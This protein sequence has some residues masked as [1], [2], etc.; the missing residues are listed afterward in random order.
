MDDGRWT[1]DDGRWTMD[2]GRWTMDDGR[3][4]MDNFVGKREG[5][6]VQLV[7]GEMSG[8]RFYWLLAALR[9]SQVTECKQ[10]YSFLCG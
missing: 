10:I 5:R 3:W 7:D 6:D 9:S 1:M 2:D 4:T 8:I